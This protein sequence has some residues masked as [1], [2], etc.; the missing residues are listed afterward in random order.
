MSSEESNH[1]AGHTSLTLASTLRASGVAVQLAL[2]PTALFHLS[3]APLLAGL[4]MTGAVAAL[5]TSGVLRW[6]W[7]GLAANDVDKDVALSEAHDVGTT[8]T[9]PIVARALPQPATSAPLRSIAPAANDSDS[10]AGLCA[11]LS[12]ELRTP[13]N[14]VLGF[15]E[16]MKSELHGPLGRPRYREYVSH[17]RESGEALLKT[18][19]DAL[20]ITS[21]LS[22][23]HR[24][25]TAVVRGL[26]VEPLIADAWHFIEPKA[27]ARGIRLVLD[28]PAG[29]E[30]LGDHRALRQALI[31]LVE[32][33]LNRTAGG[34]SIA[35]TA[36]AN[37]GAVQLAISTKSHASERRDD[38]LALHLARALIEFNGSEL[39]IATRSG[40]WTARTELDQASQSDFFA[41]LEAAD[42]K[43]HDLRAARA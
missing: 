8:E 43:V 38:T 24:Q 39:E 11:R 37:A 5:A 1:A 17:I 15:S 26:A 34:G 20:A 18:T 10:W 29:L 31:N 42:L 3:T 28:V 4:A 40:R 33:A 27:A 35:F 41:D 9:T 21:V 32:E 6:H 25:S 7:M 13:L 2:V 22:G 16:L 30:I 23:I 14:A 12:H 36:T 19:E